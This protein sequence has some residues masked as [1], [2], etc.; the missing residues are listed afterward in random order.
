[1][2]EKIT[3]KYLENEKQ[4]TIN[5]DYTL[6][7][8][9]EK[10]L[11]DANLSPYDIHVME[12]HYKDGTVT[13]IG[14]VESNFYHHLSDVCTKGKI[15]SLVIIPRIRDENDNAL[16]SEY[17]DNYFSYIQAREDERIAKEMQQQYYYQRHLPQNE[18]QES[19]FH[20]VN[21][22]I[23]QD[24]RENGEDTDGDEEMESNDDDEENVAVNN[25]VEALQTEVDNAFHQM[26]GS[27]LF[28][29]HVHTNNV[30]IS[31]GNDNG[32][33]SNGND[34]G[35]ISNGLVLEGGGPAGN[36]ML[37]SIGYSGSNAQNANLLPQM[38]SFI[39]SINNLVSSSLQN[40][41]NTNMANTNIDIPETTNDVNIVC[42]KQELKSLKKCLYR[43][44]EKK[45]TDTC[46][47]C[48]EDFKANSRLTI[49]NCKHY[50]HTRCINHWLKNS[51]I[52]PVCKEPTAKGK[53]NTK[54]SDRL[55]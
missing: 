4:L 8:I 31:N 42:T 32:N 54:I 28:Q 36:A 43:N 14:D 21:Q 30:N 35:N 1:M 6:G 53:S 49:L 34:N 5:H 46:N 9:E 47:I 44:I 50:Y 39:N 17:I 51:V 26:M 24:R 22:C 37:V 52:C 10:I 12:L 38:N 13:N 33:I 2:D 40:L 16:P 29:N 55:F 7:D 23:D 18:A 25:A 45:L 48:L 19:F 20:V 41:A 11:I 27:L 15:E 3:I